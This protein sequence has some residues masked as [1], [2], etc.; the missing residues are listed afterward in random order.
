MNLEPLLSTLAQS[1]L[2]V[3]VQASSNAPVDDPETLLK[4]AKASTQEGANLL[5]LEG[6]ENITL[7][8]AHCTVPMIGLIKR[9][10]EASEVYIT[11]TRAEVRA[12]I[13]LGCEIIALDG[14][15]RA[16]PNGETLEQLVRIVHDA[17]RI[18]LADVDRHDSGVFAR[19]CGADILSTTLSGYTRAVPRSNAPDIDLVRELKSLGLPVLAEGRY[20]EEWQVQAALAAGAIG[21]VIGGAINDPIKNTRRFAQAA[22]PCGYPVGAVDIGGTWIRYG[23]FDLDGKLARCA[24]DPTPESAEARLDWITDQARQDGVCAIGIS[25]GGTVDPRTLE[26]WEAKP[27]IPGHEG[28]SFQPLFDRGFERVVALN[29]G[30]ATAWGHALLPETAG[31]RIATLALGTGVGFGLVDQGRIWMGPRGEYPRLN[32]IVLEGENSF[33]DL[34]GGAVLGKEPTPGQIRD[35]NEAA[36]RAVELIERIYYPEAIVVCGGVGLAPWLEIE[37]LR[38]P[39]G[40]LAGLIGAAML[41]RNPPMGMR[42]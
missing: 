14:T 3:S 10:Y 34:L 7:I 24:F 32:D 20:T 33:E 16:R 5:R 11:P 23:H 15:N 12:L 37:A 26:V 17:G 13:E 41:V 38:S 8:R 9:E 29:D 2:I 19:D 25:T 6:V 42:G 18:A 40:E 35:A 4:L 39:Y 30:L 1:P 27:I 31:K 22:E 36:A 21:V 28:S